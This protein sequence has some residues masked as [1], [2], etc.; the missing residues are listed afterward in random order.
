MPLLA[1]ESLT[2]DYG[3]FRA[4]D[5][6]NL[7]IAPGEVVG[8][9]GPNGSGKSTALR[10]VLGF[11]RPTAGK[12]TVAGFDCWSQSVEVRKRVAYLPGELRLYENMTG[13]QLVRFLGKLR[14]EVPGEEVDQLAK[15]LDIDVDKPLV[16]MSSGMKRKVALLAILVPKVP[17]IILDEPTNT[18]DPTMRD[19]LLEQLALAK[20]AGK[21]VLFS[22]HV[23]QEVEAVCDRVVILRKGLL[24]HEQCMADLR[25]GRHVTAA[26]TG[27]AP[28]LGPDGNALSIADGRLNLEYRG[29]LPTL[30]EWLAKQPLGNLKIEPL[31]LGPIYHKYHGNV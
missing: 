13:R 29:P 24:V 5:G 16:Q 10:M 4:L 21:A 18:L 23:L 8:L 17:L 20:R 19:E 30:L 28:T 26:L 11:M 2:K 12:A 22:S 25:D 3:P 14:G 9:L 6:L 1:T 15:R 27:P 31:G 7:A